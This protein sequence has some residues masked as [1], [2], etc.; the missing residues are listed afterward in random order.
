MFPSKYNLTDNTYTIYNGH[1][2]NTKNTF[3][4]PTRLRRWNRQSVPKRRHT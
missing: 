2:R 4:I 3:F 1:K